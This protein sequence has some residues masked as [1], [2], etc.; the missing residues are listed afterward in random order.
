MSAALLQPKRGLSLPN[1]C[2]GNRHVSPLPSS[3]YASSSSLGISVNTAA[4]IPCPAEVSVDNRAHCSAEAHALT[5]EDGS[6]QTRLPSSRP[7][8]SLGARVASQSLSLL[9]SK[10]KSKRCLDNHL[11][12]PRGKTAG[13]RQLRSV[14]YPPLLPCCHQGPALAAPM[15]LQLLVEALSRTSTRVPYRNRSLA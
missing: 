15:S 2:T 11:L 5:A 10:R 1:Y 8:H 4:C 7:K 6:Y 14:G 13:W 3:T 12:R 9:P